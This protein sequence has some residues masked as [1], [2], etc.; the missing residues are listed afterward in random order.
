M[1]S[2]D[3]LANGTFT[4]ANATQAQLTVDI[5]EQHDTPTSIAQ[6]VASH[7]GITVGD[8][9][10]PSYTVGLYYSGETTGRQILDDLCAGL[11]AYWYLNAL[12]EL[13]VRQHV[14]PATADVTLFSD[15][16][17]YDQIGLAETQSP[18]ASLNLRWG[19]NYSTLS[20]VAGV[21]ED[22]DAAEAARLKPGMVGI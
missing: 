21:I 2:T 15:E 10:L 22:N 8:V 1:P 6:W 3:D 4:L 20:T 17:E 16:I 14:I 12:G 13:V 9:A 7:Y 11:G 18:W 5:E 19:R